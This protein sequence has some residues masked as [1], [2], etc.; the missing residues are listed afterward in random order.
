[1][2]NVDGYKLPR[3]QWE[4]LVVVKTQ[5]LLVC[6]KSV[7]PIVETKYSFNVKLHAGDLS[8]YKVSLVSI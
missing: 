5:A 1:M 3:T 4:K 7:N 8:K 6:Y 2:C